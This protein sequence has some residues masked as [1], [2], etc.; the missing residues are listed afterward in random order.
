MRK[1]LRTLLAF[2]GMVIATP[3]WAVDASYHTWDGFSET[4]DAFRIVALIFSD[5][6]YETLVV[7]IAVVGIG[8]GA[9]L[10]GIRGSGM[11]L[12]AFGFQM[13]VGI[14]LFAGMI[15]TTGTVHVYDRVR[16]AYQPV[17]GVPNLIVLVA[18]VTNLMERALAET[19][20]DNTSD[21]NAKLEFG[22]GGHSFDLFLNAVSPRSPIVDSFL[23][24]TVKDYVRQCYPVA[25]VSP[26]YGVDDDQ[27]F[28]TSTDLPASFQPWRVRQPSRRSIAPATRPAP[29]CPASGMEPILPTSLPILRCSTPIA[30]RSAR[31]PASM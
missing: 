27:L 5:P 26:A 6:R 25:R 28:R 9:V 2:L 13:L 8:L 30:I 29:P 31:A 4:V 7:I 16:N 11:G 15:A 20:D 10:A 3:A 24:A 12:V 14:G 23:D 21:P 1:L 18:G 19:I 17:G 22:A